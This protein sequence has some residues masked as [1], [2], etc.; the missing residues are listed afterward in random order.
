MPNFSI[1]MAYMDGNNSFRRRNL[2]A[3]IDRCLALMPDAEI[4]IAEQGESSQSEKLSSYNPRLKRIQVDEG[5]RFHKTKL[6]NEAIKNTVSDVIVMVDADSYLNDVAAKSIDEGMELLKNNCAG[7][8][9]PYDGV[10]YLTEGY[11]RKLLDGGTINS[12]FCFHGVHIQRQTGLCNMYLKSSWEKVR[13][14]DEEF[15]EWGAEDD[16]FTYKIKRAVGPVMRM[17]G[18]IYHLFHP[19]VNTAPYME[20]MVYTNNRKLCACIRRMTN[21]DFDSFLAK[22][23][24]LTELVEKYDKKKRLNVRLQWPCTPQTLLTVDTTIYDIDYEGEMSFTKILNAVLI[25]D[26]AAYIPTFV[27]EIFDEIPDL[28]PEQRKEIDDY[29]A[30]AKKLVEMG[31]E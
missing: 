4:V 29:V 2:F 9:Y 18:Y 16:A 31:A 17:Q 5:K 12:K 23:V 13:G 20:S 22:K 21:E 3:V 27:H 24:S 10:D 19:Q 30:H 26:G 25:E 11:T 8:V 28:S 7:I 15:Y 1:V 6:L 14:F